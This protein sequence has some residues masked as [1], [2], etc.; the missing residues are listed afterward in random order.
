MSD[1]QVKI[2]IISIQYIFLYSPLSWSV[3][4]AVSV[5]DIAPVELVH[6]ALIHSLLARVEL[7]V[8]EAV[9]VRTGLA[10]VQQV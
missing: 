9:L 1:N 6:H 3:P 4:H 8:E 10:G 5:A 7:G 2:V